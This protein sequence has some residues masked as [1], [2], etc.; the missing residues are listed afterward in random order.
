MMRL[1][2]MIG[3]GMGMGTVEVDMDECRGRAATQRGTIVRETV[4]SIPLQQLAASLALLTA[5]VLFK[6]TKYIQAWI[7]CGSGIS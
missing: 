4:A 3:P 5:M 1:A 6:D 2:L 7:C